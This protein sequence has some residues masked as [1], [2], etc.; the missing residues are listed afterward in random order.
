MHER[1]KSVK[2]EL[3]ACCEALYNTKELLNVCRISMELSLWSAE[4][5]ISSENPSGPGEGHGKVKCRNV[6]FFNGFFPEFT[7]NICS[8]ISCMQLTS[9]KDLGVPVKAVGAETYSSRYYVLS[10]REHWLC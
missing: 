2:S 5:V 7:E 9:R 3:V 8:G 6:F 4:D 1:V 10:G